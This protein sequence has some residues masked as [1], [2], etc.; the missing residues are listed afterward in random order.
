VV[1]GSLLRLSQG[2]AVYGAYCPRY[3]G[4]ATY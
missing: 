2:H 3:G 4:V 1:V